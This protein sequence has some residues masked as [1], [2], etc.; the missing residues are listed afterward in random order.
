MKSYQGECGERDHRKRLDSWYYFNF[1][2]KM[3][4]D[5]SPSY[6]CECL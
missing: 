2:C 4:D 3:R 1:K 5:L 6:A